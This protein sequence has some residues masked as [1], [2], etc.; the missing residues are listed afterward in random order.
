MNKIYKLDL[1]K[2]ELQLILFTRTLKFGKFEIDMRN[3]II[4]DHLKQKEKKI[5]LNEI[6]ID[7]L[8]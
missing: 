4:Q 6:P 2:K 7:K 5:N 3:G 8:I 1:T